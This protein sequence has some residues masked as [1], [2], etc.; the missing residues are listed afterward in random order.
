MAA[1]RKAPTTVSVNQRAGM[2]TMFGNG[3]ASSSNRVAQFGDR[4][5]D[6]M[7]GD[8]EAVSKLGRSARLAILEDNSETAQH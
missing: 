5:N 1:V 4:L 7:E 3:P 8:L 2:S 6:M